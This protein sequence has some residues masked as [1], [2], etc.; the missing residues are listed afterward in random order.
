LLTKKQFDQL[1]DWLHAKARNESLAKYRAEGPIRVEPVNPNATQKLA[2]IEIARDNQ[3][4]AFSTSFRLTSSQTLR[5][6]CVNQER[7]M[8]TCENE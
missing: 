4:R 6:T 5:I 7:K 2:E 3:G 8:E 1:L